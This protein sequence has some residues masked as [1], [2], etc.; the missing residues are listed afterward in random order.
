M[1]NSGAVPDVRGRRPLERS[2]SPADLGSCPRIGRLAGRLVEISAGPAGAPLALAFRLVLEAQRAGEPTAWVGRRDFPFFPPDV[3]EA[4]VDLSAFP[5]VWAPDTR[6]AT[7]AAD[8]LVRS[9]GFGLVVVDLG[10][11]PHLPLA[12]VGR[13]AALARRHGAALVLIT[14]KDPKRP[15]LGSLVSL[16]AHAGRLVRERGRYRFETHILKDK[17]GRPAGR[18][19]EVCLGPDG[20]R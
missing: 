20:L 19:E 11:D 9:G 15:S 18:F 2:A 14:E 4:G 6:A 13:L 10:V 8:F 3:A 17:G 12:A 5:V 7:G 1:T 16:R